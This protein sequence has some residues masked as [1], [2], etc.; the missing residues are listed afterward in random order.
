MFILVVFLWLWRLA[1]GAPPLW[2]QDEW[3]EGCEYELRQRW[4]G[5][6]TVVSVVEDRD[7]K[8]FLP[9]LWLNLCLFACLFLG[10]CG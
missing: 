10:C 7:Q 6:V 3:V 5:P 9:W 4:N 8:F 1:D 2:P